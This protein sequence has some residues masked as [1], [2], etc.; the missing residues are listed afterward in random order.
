MPHIKEAKSA[1]FTESLFFFQEILKRRCVN[2]KMI[3]SI[4][5]K[6]FKVFSII[7]F[8]LLIIM[9]TYRFLSNFAGL[10]IL[11][12]CVRRDLIKNAIAKLRYQPLRVFSK[13]PNLCLH[14]SVF[15]SIHFGRYIFSNSD[16]WSLYFLRILVVASD[17]SPD[18]LTSSS[19]P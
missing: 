18:D 3:T 17:G 13:H 10:T 6:G 7:I 1:K 19:K 8:L 12:K 11:G 16:F 9:G 2:N 14:I 4:F 5:N 15:D